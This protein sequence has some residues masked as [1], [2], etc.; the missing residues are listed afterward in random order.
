MLDVSYEQILFSLKCYIK[1]YGYI[2]I[3]LLCYKEHLDSEA[4]NLEVDHQ[5]LSQVYKCYNS[6][7]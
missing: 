4:T 7:L 1:A 2:R 6:L 5:Y 3:Y